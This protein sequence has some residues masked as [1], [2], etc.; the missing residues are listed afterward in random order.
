[1]CGVTGVFE[2]LSILRSS[3]DFRYFTGACFLGAGMALEL[4]E[5]LDDFSPSPK[6]S[7]H[8]KNKLI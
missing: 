3:S 5:K 4:A 6:T 7:L 1:M 2:S 8:V